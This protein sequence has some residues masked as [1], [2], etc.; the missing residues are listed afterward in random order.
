MTL[1][2]SNIDIDQFYYTTRLAK[3]MIYLLFLCGNY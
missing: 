2:Y 3:I 1:F